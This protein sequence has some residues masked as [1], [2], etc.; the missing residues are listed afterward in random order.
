MILFIGAITSKKIY[1]IIWIGDGIVEL[2]SKDSNPVAYRF[3]LCLL[4]F[5][6]MFIPLF[7]W[8]VNYLI[9]NAMSL[10]PES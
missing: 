2:T 4:A 9:H 7:V 6:L 5:G 3:L 8:G 1:F 10:G